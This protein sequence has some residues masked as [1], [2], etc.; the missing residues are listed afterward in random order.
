M[1]SFPLN[2]TQT[3]LVLGDDDNWRAV[4]VKTMLS[5]GAY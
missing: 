2:Y 4:E 3:K 5:K 1:I